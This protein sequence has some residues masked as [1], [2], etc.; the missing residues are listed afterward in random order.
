MSSI[1]QTILSALANEPGEQAIMD[2]LVDVTGEDKRRLSDNI[3]QAVKDGLVGRQKDIVTGMPLYQL[4]SKGK[5]RIGKPNQQPLRTAKP[6]TVHKSAH[7]SSIDDDDE[8]PPADAGL[9]ASA[10]R[11]LSDRL[12]GVAHALRGSGLPGLAN[13]KDGEDLLQYVA[14]LAGAYQMA[15]SGLTS[16]EAQLSRMDAAMQQSSER[17]EAWRD[18]AAELGCDSP[19]EL[20]DYCEKLQ[21]ES[22][23]GVTCI[24]PV[25]PAK[26]H[27]FAVM[28]MD[29]GV[30]GTRDEAADAALATLRHDPGIGYKVAV[31]EIVGVAQNVV[32]Q[33]WKEAA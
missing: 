3:A 28:L 32:V 27:G 30:Y 9:L 17:L 1:R 6:Q 11:M 22:I 20:R 25:K 24:Q 23:K 15:A 33:Q 2:T 5:D 21:A 8:M 16:A 7:K 14:A 4:T 13:I 31:V 18:M 29:D 19:Y 12:A 26:T 10:N